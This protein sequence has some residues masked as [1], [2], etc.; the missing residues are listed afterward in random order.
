[1]GPARLSF[2]DDAPRL[3]GAAW[4]ATDGPPQPALT[5]FDEGDEVPDHAG[6]FPA[7]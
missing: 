4:I 5:F 2:E 3:G 6:E 7:A 1:M